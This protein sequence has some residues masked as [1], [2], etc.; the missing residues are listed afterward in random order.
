[1]KTHRVLSV[2]RCLKQP[3]YRKSLARFILG[4][5]MQ[6]TPQPAQAPAAKSNTW[7]LIA[8]VIVVLIVVGVAAYELF[9]TSSGPKGTQVTMFENTSPICNPVQ[10][11]V[12]GFK[13]S[14]GSNSTTITAGTSIYWTNNGGL[15]HTATS[16]DSTNA[17][18]YTYTCPQAN[19][20]LPSFDIGS[21][22][23]GKSS[24]SVTL[25]TAGTYYYFCYI[26]SWMHGSVIVK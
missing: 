3:L 19:G 22:A 11:P 25:S 14:S 9:G 16:C 7:K 13:D 15:P 17:A 23:S 18:K 26:H 5:K 6:T 8:I 20:S 10:P 12:C 1:M 21:L 24:S 2:C 4:R